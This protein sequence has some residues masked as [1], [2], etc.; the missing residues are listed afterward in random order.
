MGNQYLEVAVEAAG[1]AGSILLSEFDQP[2]KNQLQGRSGHRDAGRPRSEEA[3]VTRLRAPFPSMPSWP[4]KAAGRRA[5]RRFAGIVDPL[6]GTTN[7]AH[8]YP[9]FAV[10]IG[11]EEAGELIVGVIYQP[12]TQGDVHR[13]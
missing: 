4:R 8:G 13:R 12:V 10:S 2:G 7:F 1:E 9:C 11:L 6:D 3:I 5:I